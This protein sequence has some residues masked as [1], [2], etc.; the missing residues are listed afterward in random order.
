MPLRRIAY[1]KKPVRK[2]QAKKR[3]V[4]GRGAYSLRSAYSKVKP[5]I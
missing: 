2:Y 4:K 5:Y 3:V 1:K